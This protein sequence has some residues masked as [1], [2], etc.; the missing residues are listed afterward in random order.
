MLTSEASHQFVQTLDQTWLVKGSKASRGKVLMSSPHL[1][2]EQGEAQLIALHQ[3]HKRGTSSLWV[4]ID[5]PLEGHRT[6][7]P[8]G[9][10]GRGDMGGSLAIADQEV[11]G[12]GPALPMPLGLAGPWGLRC[13]A[14]TAAA[15]LTADRVQLLHPPG[16]QALVVPCLRPWEVGSQNPWEEGP[17][18]VHPLRE[19]DPLGVPPLRFQGVG[20]PGP[21]LAVLASLEEQTHC[22]HRDWRLA[23]FK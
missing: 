5:S 1:S 3:T 20:T 18:G 7:R 4:W 2:E 21:S 14:A 9:R 12:T 17:F 8:L 22:I 11:L 16:S 23:A 19:E 15:H 10:R 6:L 13:L